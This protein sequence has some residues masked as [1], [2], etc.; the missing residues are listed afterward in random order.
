MPPK[1]PR[2]CSTALGNDATPHKQEHWQAPVP[3]VLPVPLAIEVAGGGAAAVV[4]AGGAG[5]AAGGGAGGAVPDAVP[6]C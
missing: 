1:L 6:F 4:A 2:P 5:G 3:S